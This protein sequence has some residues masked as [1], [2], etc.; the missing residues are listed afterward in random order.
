MLEQLR[1]VSAVVVFDYVEDFIY[2]FILRTYWAAL[3]LL[4][5]AASYVPQ[6]VICSASPHSSPT[7]FLHLH[8]PNFSLLS[9]G[10]GGGGSTGEHSP[11]KVIPSTQITSFGCTSKC[12]LL[13]LFIALILPTSKR[14]YHMTTDDIINKYKDPNI[15]TQ[16]HIFKKVMIH[17][18]LTTFSLIVWHKLLVIVRYLSW[19]KENKK[20]TNKNKERIKRSH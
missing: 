17:T 15:N 8:N 14:K 19:R 13:Y 10:W 2:L 6:Y 20:Q 3:F 7:N 18:I 5:R 9:W 1:N 16:I 11:V 4:S 12:H